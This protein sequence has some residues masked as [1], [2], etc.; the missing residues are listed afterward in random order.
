VKIKCG[1]EVGEN[2]NLAK[3]EG[4][5]GSVDLC[6]VR[7]EAV[8][9]TAKQPNCPEEKEKA[10]MKSLEHFGMAYLKYIQQMT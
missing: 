3:L 7:T 5:S 8:A 6:S 4:A 9:K 10:I 2:Y 1:I